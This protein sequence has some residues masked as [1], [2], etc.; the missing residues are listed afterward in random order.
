MT[1]YIFPA[2]LAVARGISSTLCAILAGLY[3]AHRA[4]ALNGVEALA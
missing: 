2:R 1:T 3:P 4:A